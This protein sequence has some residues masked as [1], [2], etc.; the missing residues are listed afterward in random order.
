MYGS[1]RLFI[2]KTPDAVG[3]ETIVS[4][5]DVL[6][7]ELG[8]PYD[9]IQYTLPDP[10][11]NRDLVDQV[12][13]V[14]EAGRERFRKEEIIPLY[15]GCHGDLSTPI[16]SASCDQESCSLYKN[17]RI[18]VIFPHDCFPFEIS[19]DFDLKQRKKPFDFSSY[20]GIL[21]KVETMGFEINNSF[22]SIYGR[23]NLA[24]TFDGGQIGSFPG[25]SGRRN[26]E[27]AVLHRKHLC[28]NRLQ[29]VYH[30]NSLKRSS[31][32][33]D[34]MKEIHNVVEDSNLMED[35]D[36]FFFALST[37]SRLKYHIQKY[38]AVRILKNSGLL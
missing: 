25:L 28:M 33:P 32:S 2:E 20:Q 7:A 9:F 29:S 35:K 1:L 8:I 11:S 26:I 21:S 27:S 14:N 31:I 15:T 37:S 36:S 24:A 34:V 18:R 10:D 30:F 13:P 4:L 16:F 19:A 6:S 22:C 12:F 3:A 38:R 17:I 23:K 5:M